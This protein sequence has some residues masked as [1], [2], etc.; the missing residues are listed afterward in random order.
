MTDYKEEQNNEIEALESIYPDEITVLSTEPFHSFKILVS[1]EE[2]TDETE[3]NGGRLQVTLQFTYTA[4]YPDEAPV[5]QVIPDESLQDSHV[6][7]LKELL[8][9]QI[10]ENMGMAMVF[11]LVS[12]SQEFLNERVDDIK[13]EKEKQLEKEEE[14]KRKAEEER[15][16]LLKGTPVT[17]ETFL[18][19]K[20]KFDKEMAEM[21]K[22]NHQQEGPTKRLTGKELFMSDNALDTSDM[23]LLDE[24]DK[25]QVDESLFQDMGDL[26]L[27]EELDLEDDD[28]S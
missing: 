1:S 16:Q 9:E 6:E 15:D 5:Y 21:T 8:E 17:I 2:S 4:S 19:W 12:A 27:E 25:V 14:E 24:S 26:D 11:A 28:E 3:D 10:E 20:E 23:D 7:R 13:K 18:T 22:K